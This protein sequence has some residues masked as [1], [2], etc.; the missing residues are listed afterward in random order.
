[1]EPRVYQRRPNPDYKPRPV[2]NSTWGPTTLKPN[3]NYTSLSEFARAGAAP[4]PPTTNNKPSRPGWGPLI[5]LA[6]NFQPPNPTVAA[7][8]TLCAVIVCYS[9][10]WALDGSS[11]SNSITFGPRIEV[12]LNVSAE[13]S[14]PAGAYLVAG[15]S[16]SGVAGA[17]AEVG[18]GI[19]DDGLAG[20]TSGTVRVGAGGGCTAGIRWSD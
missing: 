3:F 4:K 13:V 6:P 14:S 7:G 17:G 12:T 2:T 8:F 10:D 11:G 19:G 9:R 5:G 20:T 1:M 15:C 16:A 18:V